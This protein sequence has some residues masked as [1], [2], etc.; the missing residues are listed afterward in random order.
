[1][2]R[3]LGQVDPGVIS[4]DTARL[5]IRVEAKG[6]NVAIRIETPDGERRLF[7][8]EHHPHRLGAVALIEVAP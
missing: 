8:V 5:Y 2:V 6:R 3:R 4:F 7:Q 1:M